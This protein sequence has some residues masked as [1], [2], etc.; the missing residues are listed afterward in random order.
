[1][2]KA[3]RPRLDVLLVER[4]LVDSRQKAQGLILS[5]KV[6]VNDTPVTKAGTRLKPDVAIRIKGAPLPF[7]SRG[8]LKLQAALDAFGVSV[9]DRVCA[10]LGASTGGFTDCLLQRGAAK[11]HAVDVGYG[12]LAWSLRQ[13][14][15][16]QVWERTNARHLD[17]LGEPI[18]LLVGDLS[19]ISLRKI[20][21]AVARLAAPGADCVLLVK[22]QFEVG[23]EGLAKGGLVRDVGL[24]DAAVAAVLDDAVAAGFDAK[25]QIES[26]ITGAKSGNVEFLV[27]LVAPLE[28]PADPR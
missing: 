16:V 12:Q 10:D 14:P 28:Q 6:L 3:Q 13:D 8:G 11:V 15:R 1:M 9:D 23:R 5:G 24:R 21:P 19:F 18:E 4:G 26:P 7:V 27:W 2:A 25:G 20:L 17:T 22:P